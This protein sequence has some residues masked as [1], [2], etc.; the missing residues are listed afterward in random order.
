MPSLS[1]PS[2]CANCVVAGAPGSVPKPNAFSELLKTGSWIP[3]LPLY[4]MVIESFGPKPFW[5]SRFHF[6]YCGA[7]VLGC[8]NVILGVT[9]RVLAP[10]ANPVLKAPFAAVAQSNRL[11]PGLWL[12]ARNPV[13]LP[14]IDDDRIVKPTSPGAFCARLSE[15]T[16]GKMS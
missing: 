4:P 6:W 5:I 11:L 15:M 7:W 12:G 8:V 10:E 9:G 2:T 13:Q 14:P 16:P 1:S 3:W